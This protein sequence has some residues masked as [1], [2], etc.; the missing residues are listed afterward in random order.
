[1]KK[2]SI[3]GLAAILMNAFNGTKKR[4]SEQPKALRKENR[5]FEKELAEHRGLKEF[6]INGVRVFALNQKNAERKASGRRPFCWSDAKK[7]TDDWRVG[8]NEISQKI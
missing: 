2:R 8:C 6:H 3:L 4:I 5:D 1:M 7:I